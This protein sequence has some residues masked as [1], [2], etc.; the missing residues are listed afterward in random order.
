MIQLS[1]HRPERGREALAA[2][3]I[4]RSLLADKHVH[5]APLLVNFQVGD[6]V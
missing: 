5:A 6:R 2:A 1:Q 4:D 3:E